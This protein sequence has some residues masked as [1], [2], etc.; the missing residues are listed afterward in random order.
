M[1]AEDTDIRRFELDFGLVIWSLLDGLVKGE[2]ESC[3]VPGFRGLVRGCFE[4]VHG[5]FVAGGIEPGSIGDRI[6]GEWGK[7]EKMVGEY[8]GG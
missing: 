1:N 4:E 6:K 3:T 8:L 2:S 7:V 5:Q